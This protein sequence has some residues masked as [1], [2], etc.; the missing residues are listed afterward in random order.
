MRT[1]AFDHIA[2]A[3]PR[4]AD[5]VPFFVG[6][7]GGAPYDGMQGGPEFQF[8]TWRYDGGGK[9]EVIITAA[10]GASARVASVSSV[11]RNVPIAVQTMRAGQIMRGAA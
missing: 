9:L 10:A 1:I 4:I 7:L 3:L 8:G 2:L 5:A 6:V 11:N